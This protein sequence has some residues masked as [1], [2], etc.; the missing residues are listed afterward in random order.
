MRIVSKINSGL[1]FACTMIALVIAF[2]PSPGFG[3][4]IADAGGPYIIDVGQDLWLDGSRSY[5]T[6]A[7]SGNYIT[8][9]VWAFEFMANPFAQGATVAVPY[10]V[11]ENEIELR[12]GTGIILDASYQFN[13][14]VKDLTGRTD[15]ETTTVLIR[16]QSTPAPVPE[17]STMA[18]LGAGLLCV[19]GGRKIRRF[20]SS[21][22]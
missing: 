4:P 15:N 12:T 7:V 5:V 13:L 16:S 6:D 8:R 22:N 9:Y 2:T 21:G 18:L 11:L 3:I 1:V 17:P 10:A 14:W 20:F 19:A